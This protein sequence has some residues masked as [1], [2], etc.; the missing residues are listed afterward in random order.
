MNLQQLLFWICVFVALGILAA[1]YEK[2]EMITAPLREAGIYLA[3]WP[4]LIVITA[5]SVL[6]AWP[7]IED[8]NHLGRL[9][10]ATVQAETLQSDAIRE[11]L[12]KPM[13][14]C[15]GEDVQRKMNEAQATALDA[16]EEHAQATAVRR[17][18][19]LS[20]QC[21]PPPANRPK[22]SNG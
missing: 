13:D 10:Y 4:T 8:Y 17:S 3:L 15:T 6:L 19:P 11:L 9:S 7:E 5:L 2:F 18:Q 16:I 1:V 21:T 20:P 22:P 12:D 14:E